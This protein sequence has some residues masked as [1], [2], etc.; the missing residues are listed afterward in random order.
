MEAREA[1]VGIERLVR[2]LHHVVRGDGRRHE[3]VGRGG[4][5]A[6]VAELDVEARSAALTAAGD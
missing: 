6:R 3:T 1:V 5:G 2:V 4:V